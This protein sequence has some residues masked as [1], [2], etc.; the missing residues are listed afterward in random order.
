MFMLLKDGME[1]PNYFKVQFVKLVF[2]R[3]L[4]YFTSV[5]N[6]LAK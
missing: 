5:P 6:R 3:K 1:I 2:G 4:K